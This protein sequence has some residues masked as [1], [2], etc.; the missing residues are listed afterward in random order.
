MGYTKNATDIVYTFIKEKI[1]KNEWRHGERIYTEAKL[2][3]ELG[4]SRVA[5]RQAISRLEL[6]SVLYSVQGSGTY[7]RDPR[8]LD[9]MDLGLDCIEYEDVISILEYRKYYEC[10]NIAL[11]IK[12]AD[13]NDIAELENCYNRMKKKCHI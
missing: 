2:S 7:V 11:F 3:E 5:V 6:V 12:F 9:D 10:G 1:A 8:M 13:E 4:V